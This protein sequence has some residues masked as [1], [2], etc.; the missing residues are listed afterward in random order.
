MMTRTAP[1]PP[2]TEPR[3][4]PLVCVGVVVGNPLALAVVRVSRRPQ[5]RS[6]RSRAGESYR[7][8]LTF[9]RIEQFSITTPDLAAAVDMVAAHVHQTSA[10]Y[11][12]APVGFLPCREVP[13]FGSGDDLTTLILN[14]A[15]AVAQRVTWPAAREALTGSPRRDPAAAIAVASNVLLG[16]PVRGGS[17]R[18]WRE[19]VTAN[20]HRHAMALGAGLAVARSVLWHERLAGLKAGVE[21]VGQR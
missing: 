19:V 21:G 15:G 2:S 11:D 18:Y 4:G 17:P 16:Y 20:Y 14:R 6:D 3:T 8:G 1:E 9:W 13:P 5:F 12:D 7:P 10:Y